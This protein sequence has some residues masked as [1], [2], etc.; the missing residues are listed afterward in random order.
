M[1]AEIHED[2]FLRVFWDRTTRVISIDWKES[3]SAMT[4]D[5]FKKEL[6]L[7]ADYVERQKAQGVLVDVANFRHKLVPEVQEW[8]VKNI[9][10]RYGAA[11]VTRFAFL[12]PIDAPIPPMLNRSSPGEPFVTRGFNRADEAL[13]WLSEDRT[14]R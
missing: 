6:T 1:P 13:A 12:L 3:T 2:T 4:D 9:S 11:G 10:V 7:F 14:D 8:R 5:D